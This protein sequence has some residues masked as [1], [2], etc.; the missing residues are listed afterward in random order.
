M[1]LIRVRITGNYT[2]SRV[3]SVMLHDRV[4]AD[5]CSFYCSTELREFCYSFSRDSTYYSKHWN[6]FIFEE[7]TF[8]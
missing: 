1:V 4:L 2:Y 8:L 7:K 5:N 3:T 6:I